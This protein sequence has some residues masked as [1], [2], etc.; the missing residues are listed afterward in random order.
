MKQKVALQEIQE[1]DK[2][3]LY[4]TLSHLARFVQKLDG[5]CGWLHNGI[6]DLIPIGIFL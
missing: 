1:Q 2:F 3:V 4:K 6:D 5:Y